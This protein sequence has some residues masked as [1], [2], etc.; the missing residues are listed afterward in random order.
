MSEETEVDSIE[1]GQGGESQLGGIQLDLTR[2]F[3]G[4]KCQVSN[5]A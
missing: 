5:K 2:Q 1:G 4:D 3:E